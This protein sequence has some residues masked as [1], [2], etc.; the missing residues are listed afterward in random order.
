M[1]SVFV[2]AL[3]LVSF[4][5]RMQ[6]VEPLRYFSPIEVAC[7]G[8]SITYG[9][10]I[11]NCSH[12]LYLSQLG[13]MLDNKWIVRNFEISGGTVL[14]KG[15]YPYWSENEN[16]QT[17]LYA[18][19]PLRDI[20]NWSAWKE[21]GVDDPFQ[22]KELQHA[23]N[24]KRENKAPVYADNP[25]DN[26]EGLTAAKDPLFFSID[27]VP[28]SENTYIFVNKYIQMEGMDTVFSS[29]LG[30]QTLKGQY[31]PMD[32][33]KTE[34][35]FIQDNSYRAVKSKLDS[36]DYHTSR[37]KM[38]NAQIIFEREKKGRVAFL[39]G[40]I[41]YNPGWRDSIC[42][43]LQN[44]FPETKFDFI[45]A[46]I[47]SLG[48]TPGAFR[49]ERDV[50]AHGRVDLLFEEAAVNDRTNGFS[51]EEQ[52]MGM[53]GIVRHARLSNPA[54]DIIIMNFVDPEKMDD[55]RKG[56]VP[57]EVANFEKVAAR[58][59]VSTINLAKEVTD[60][61]DNG[62]FS[63][64]KDFV[65]LHPSPFG[66]HVY[67]QS[68]KSLLDECWDDFLAE[69]DRVTDYLLPKKLDKA[70]YDRGVLISAADVEPAKDWS[71]VQNWKPADNTGTR[72]DF[73]NVP[74]LVSKA[75]GGIQKFNF[76]GNAVGIAIASGQDAGII[77]YRIDNGKW[78]ERDLFTKWS[79]S[80]HLPWFITLRY[81]LPE[82]KHQ[83]EI[84]VL[85]KKNP[86]SKGNACRIRYFY[87]NLG[88]L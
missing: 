60:R 48:S 72:N 9:S 44:R 3:W 85:R 50:L 24:L 23:N 71:V 79:P 33:L 57:T 53:E 86:Q 41:T 32:D 49:F 12:D 73:V 7:I 80:L 64:E 10:G 76:F 26:M 59:D 11:A 65:N 8:N 78:R 82:E 45:A 54:I 51:S 81:G 14:E 66:Q 5:L 18:E 77:E 16:D 39:G 84:R 55:Y 37:S 74:M 38:N 69:D 56:I 63:W 15:D 21:V 87:V 22:W 68:I 6:T 67:Y 36:R 62:E 83:L 25:V 31:S 17:D 28:P 27:I 46:G 13:R 42:D 35:E 19:A 58:Y 47:P 43:Y 61:I 1:R 88:E 4:S 70:C 30:K 2:L 20:K 40:S 75:P 29:T 52:I 34:T